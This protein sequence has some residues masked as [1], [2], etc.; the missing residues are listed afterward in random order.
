[1]LK[2][3]YYLITLF[4]IT[5]IFYSKTRYLLKYRLVFRLKLLKYKVKSKI[6]KI[7][8]AFQ[9]IHQFIKSIFPK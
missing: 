2:S 6:I 4:E 9:I 3:D 5:K 1:M 7:Y 8:I